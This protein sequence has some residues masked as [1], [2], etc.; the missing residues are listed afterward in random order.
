M[1][2]RNEF[3]DLSQA[4]FA[5]DA[6][7]VLGLGA[8]SGD[9]EFPQIDRHARRDLDPHHRT[10]AS[11]LQAR[12]ELT[13]QVLR[14]LL[15]L[16]IAVA[17]QPEKAHALHLAARKQAIEEQDQKAFESHKAPLRPPPTVARRR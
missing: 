3:R 12:L 7:H 10:Q 17:D 16:D 11:S 5:I 4:E 9:D 8:K 6:N 2:G 13:N 1:I 15:D 14:L